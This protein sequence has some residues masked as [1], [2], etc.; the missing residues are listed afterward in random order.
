[1]NVTVNYPGEMTVDESHVIGDRV[2]VYVDEDYQRKAVLLWVTP[3]QAA[4][5][6]EA[7]TPIASKEQQ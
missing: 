2:M 7:L 1:M 5:W 3:E 6:I 4:Q